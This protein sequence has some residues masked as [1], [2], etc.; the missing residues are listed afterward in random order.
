MY[1]KN[2]SRRESSEE[3]FTLVELLVVILI[4][5]ILSA[6]AIPAF[7]NQRKSAVTAALQSDMKSIALSYETWSMKPENTNAKFVQLAGGVSSPV[8]HENAA[9]VDNNTLW[10]DIEG[11]TK[12]RVSDG[13]FVNIVIIPSKNSTWK[14][15]HEENEFCIGGTNTGSDYDFISNTGMGVHNYHR[16]LY[17]DKALGGVKTAKQIA[18]AM[19]AGQKASCDGQISVWMP[20]QGMDATTYWGKYAS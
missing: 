1:F 5:G 9:G 8:R 20:S 6:I 17:Y 12:T 13:S 7:L 16:T 14:R 10:N 11:D 2:V 15:V 19:L 4:I 18:D 3:G